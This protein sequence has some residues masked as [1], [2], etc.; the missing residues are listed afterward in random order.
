MEAT[1]VELFRVLTARKLLIPRMARRAKKA[2]LPIPLY[3]Y[4]TKIFSRFRRAKPHQQPSI[5]HFSAPAK[6]YLDF[7]S[8]L[9]GFRN[10]PYFELP[11]AANLNQL[12]QQEVFVPRLPGMLHNWP[13]PLPLFLPAQ[14]TFAQHDLPW[15]DRC[16]EKFD[17]V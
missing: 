5:P 15:M 16:V 2:P 4:C 17:E 14:S 3:V 10:L 11:D 1:G 13:E 7:R 9:S 6:A 12:V 8:R